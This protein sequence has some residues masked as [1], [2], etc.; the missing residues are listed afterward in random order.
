MSS[1]S[2]EP[3]VL[4]HH[5]GSTHLDGVEAQ[6]GS[7]LA[8]VCDY[9]QV[10]AIGRSTAP[11]IQ[12]ADQQ[13]QH[14]NRQTS[15]PG[16]PIGRPEPLA[17]QSTDQQPQQSNRQ[18]SSP[19]NPIGTTEASA[20]QSTDQQPQQS[21]QQISRSADQHEFR[22]QTLASVELDQKL[23]VG[24]STDQRSTDGPAGGY[25]P[26]LPQPQLASKVLKSQ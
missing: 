11:A 8:R 1:P 20:I 6:D 24:M 17:I 19:S 7:K 15:S 5:G 26:E 2:V 21:N 12:S 18:T 16:N 10:S 22:R 9:A 14:S 25:R 3:A 4:E 23:G 13:P